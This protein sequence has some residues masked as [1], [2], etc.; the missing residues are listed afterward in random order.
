[1]KYPTAQEQLQTLTAEI[2]E[3]KKELGG[4][5]YLVTGRDRTIARLQSALEAACDDVAA[6]DKRIAELEQELEIAR[7]PPPWTL[8]Q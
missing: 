7:H 3:L 2:F 6:K 8:G 4:L 1:M 5:Q